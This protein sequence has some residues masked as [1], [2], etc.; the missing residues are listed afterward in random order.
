M[1]RSFDSDL[2]GAYLGVVSAS[3]RAGVL[4]YALVALLVSGCGDGTRPPDAEPT[5]GMLDPRGRHHG[6]TYAQ[7]AVEY[8]QWQFEAPFTAL[9]EV[10]DCTA[11]QDRDHDGEVDGPVA[12]LDS[13]LAARAEPNAC[14]FGSGKA[15]L[16]PL[17][18][19][20]SLAP[21]YTDST[22][23]AAKL[24]VEAA[25]LLPDELENS[26]ETFMERL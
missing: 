16:F 2:R 24:G 17:L 6:L 22:M 12:F 25:A 9:Y 19:L 3:G 18:P 10:K 7:W 14:A 26:V 23:K 13:D 1:R 11:W 4:A 15:I 5:I 20:T 21:Y 8:M